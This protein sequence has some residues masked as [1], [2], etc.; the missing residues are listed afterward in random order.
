VTTK[1]G[2]FRITSAGVGLMQT[3]D[4]YQSLDEY[5]R[6]NPPRV[7]RWK[8]LEEQMLA[9]SR[10]DATRGE[11]SAAEQA[12]WEQVSGKSLPAAPV[13][14]QMAAAWARFQ[15]TR[16]QPSRREIELESQLFEQIAASGF[17]PER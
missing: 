14:P 3:D 17:Q 12:L 7:P 8:E 16:P 13:S 1:T 15:A 9:N 4:G 10:R 5:N 6:Q 11:R 2:Y